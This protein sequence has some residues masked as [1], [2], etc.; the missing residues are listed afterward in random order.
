MLFVAL[1]LVAVEPPPSRPMTVEVVRDAITDAVKASATLLDDGQLL[2]LA[3][4]PQ[5]YGGLRISFSSARWLARPSFVT[6]ERP[7]VYRFDSARPE[8]QIWIMRDRGAFFG[9]HHRVRR[10]LH[11]LITSEQLVIRTR[12]V[13]DHPVELN[14][15]ISGAYP[16]VR[17]LLEA[18]GETELRTRLYGPAV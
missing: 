16:A 13:E 1:A 11:G 12:D 7:M 6:R 4:D 2:T 3:C 8:R 9:G 17:A 18:C 14:F 15:R 10:F 5:D